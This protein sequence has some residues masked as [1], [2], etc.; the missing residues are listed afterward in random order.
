LLAGLLIAVGLLGITATTAS[1][2]GLSAAQ[3][4]VGA[5]ASTLRVLVGSSATVSAAQRRV[6]GPPQ[7]AIVV[8]TGVAAETGADA[9]SFV[10]R[11]GVT[12]AFDDGSSASY[13]GEMKVA[14]G[15]NAPGEV[16]GRQYS[17]HAFDQMQGRGITPSVVDDAVGSGVMRPGTDGSSIFHSA[18][19]N[20][21][22]VVN[23]EGRVITVG[24]GAF[25]PR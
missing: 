9:T 5:S 13:G 14:R 19:N 3:T 21:S 23:Q 16:G 1:A 17:G 24:F 4:R 15:T 18:A 10:G 25:K 2:T 12:K 8:A 20:I 7:P 11:K 22:V 6:D